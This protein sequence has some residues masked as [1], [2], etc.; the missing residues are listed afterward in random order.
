MNDTQA[1]AAA[2]GAGSYTAA[3]AVSGD[4]RS[5]G[6]AVAALYSAFTAEV[7]GW[8]GVRAAAMAEAQAYLVARRLN[9]RLAAAYKRTYDV[10]AARHAAYDGE[11]YDA[12]AAVGAAGHS[13]TATI[14][15]KSAKAAKTEST[16]ATAVLA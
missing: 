12:G 8:M 14:T 6:G 5:S 10:Y 4:R 9:A 13:A 1:K 2:A 3:S 11:Q 15:G 7:G 16:T